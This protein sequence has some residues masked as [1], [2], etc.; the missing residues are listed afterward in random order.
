MYAKF[1]IFQR[2]IIYGSKT[3]QQIEP[4]PFLQQRV[5]EFFF[6]CSQNKFIDEWQFFHPP[7]PSHRTQLDFC[8]T[9]DDTRNIK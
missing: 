2:I 1:L 9:Q 6:N 5:Q 8:Q 7:V 4:Q 3:L